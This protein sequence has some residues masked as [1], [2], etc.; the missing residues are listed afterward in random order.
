MVAQTYVDVTHYVYMARFELQDLVPPYRYADTTMIRALNR[1][2]AEISRLRPDMF[3]DLKYQSPLA[4]GDIGDGIPGGY[5]I[6][7]IGYDADGNYVEGKGT[8]VPIPSKYI[9]TVEWFMPG[10]LQFTDTT[11]TQDQRAQGFMAK[12]HSHLVTLSGA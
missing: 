10:W 8:L 3:L 4:K 12:F 9:S 6:A 11:D 1:A 2:L 7:D 5:T